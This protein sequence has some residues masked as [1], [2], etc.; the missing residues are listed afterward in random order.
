M[1]TRQRFLDSLQ[2]KIDDHSLTDIT[3][4][5]TNLLEI[6][7]DEEIISVI[8]PPIIEQQKQ[9]LSPKKNSLS[10]KKN[11]VKDEV[12]KQIEIPLSPQIDE[13]LLDEPPPSKPKII[14]PPLDIKPFLK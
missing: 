6:P 2:I 5:S 14:L 13:P 12:P 1:Q 11:S 10:T 7:T 9:I 4:D 8:T 3:D